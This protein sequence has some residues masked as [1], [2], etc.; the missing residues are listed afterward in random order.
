LFVLTKQHMRREINDLARRLDSQADTVDLCEG[1]VPAPVCS[2][3]AAE[4]GRPL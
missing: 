2:I 3:S 4:P 1:L